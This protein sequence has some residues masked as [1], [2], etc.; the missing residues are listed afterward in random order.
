MPMDESKL[1]QMNK[2]ILFMFRRDHFDN[3]E[4][5][6]EDADDGQVRFYA[7]KDSDNSPNKM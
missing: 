5:Q 4:G 6:V 2:N 3:F 7:G 1:S